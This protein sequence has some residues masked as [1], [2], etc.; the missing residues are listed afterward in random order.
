MKT[1]LVI[2]TPEA[3]WKLAGLALWERALLSSKREEYQRFL[4]CNQ[5]GDST[6]FLQL[7]QKAERWGLQVELVTEAEFKQRQYERTLVT[8]ELLIAGK[9]YAIKRRSDLKSAKRA[10]YDSLYESLKKPTDGFI[11]RY[12]NRKLS[13]WL[14]SFFV[15]TPLTPNQISFSVFIGGIVAGWLVSRGT[16][17][18][19]AMGGLTFQLASILDCTDGEVAKLKYAWSKKGQWVDTICDNLSYASFLIG[20][21]LG[22]VERGVL[23]HPGIVVG[24]TFLGLFMTLGAMFYYLLRYTDSGSLVTVAKELFHDLEGQTQNWL[25]RVLM[26]VKFVMRRDFFSF[27]F[28]FLCLVNQLE[29]VLVLAAA[30]VNIAWMVLLTM[31]REFA[32]NKT[33]VL[34]ENR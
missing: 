30:G 15:W 12:I 33:P 20:V 31:K 13:R 7:A 29:W 8:D 16:Y 19:V 32:S 22:I 28:M 18:D 11:L 1:A 4:I 3:S 34:Q 9:T 27:F 5:S 21:F 25:I 24:I 2:L 26:K 17:F 14:T 6:L 10:L 23:P